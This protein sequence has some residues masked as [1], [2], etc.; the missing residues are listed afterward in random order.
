M[1]E[2]RRKSAYGEHSHMPCSSTSMRFT[3]EQILLTATGDPRTGGAPQYHLVE[4]DGV[5]G[6]LAVFLQS[7]GA[8]LLTVQKYPGLQAVATARAGDTVFIVN[9]LPGSDTFQRNK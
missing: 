3:L 7:S 5:D 4:A 9:V 1:R 2:A 6:A 8:T